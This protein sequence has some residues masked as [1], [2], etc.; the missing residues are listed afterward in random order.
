[1]VVKIDAHSTETLCFQLIADFLILLTAEIRDGIA[2][3]TSIRQGVARESALMQVPSPD[4]VS[5]RH[6]AAVIAQRTERRIG[7]SP[8]LP[9][10][11]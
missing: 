6:I 11:L 8:R 10:R 1:M 2:D 9:C 3:W 7:A 5:V 4:V